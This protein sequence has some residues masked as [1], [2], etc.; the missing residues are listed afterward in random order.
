MQKCKAVVGC[1]GLLGRKVQVTK[2][3]VTKIAKSANLQS[4]APLLQRK[5]RQGMQATKIAKKVV[6]KLEMKSRHNVE[7][8]SHVQHHHHH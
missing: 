3:Q 5:V 4:S 1:N 8:V 7:S 6:E 2:M